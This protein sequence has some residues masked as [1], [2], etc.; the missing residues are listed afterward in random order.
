MKVIISDASKRMVYH[1]QA[2]VP[3]D[4][5]LLKLVHYIE[6]HDRAKR[7]I[8]EDYRRLP[9]RT[10]KQRKFY[11]KAEQRDR[12]MQIRRVDMLLDSLKT[13]MSVRQWA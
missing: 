10:K 11:K 7:I 2:D 3:A 5:S 9:Q 13:G 6:E 1:R 4:D 12:R 8:I